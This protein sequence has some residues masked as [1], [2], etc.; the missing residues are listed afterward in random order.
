MEDCNDNTPIF[1]MTQ[2]VVTI[3]ENL[4]ADTKVL[5][6]RAFDL[7]MEDNGY[8]SYSIINMNEIPFTIDAFSGQIT[9][10]K[11]L[12]YESMSRSYKLHVR[13]S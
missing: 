4:P 9:T 7:D 10:D 1:N 12:D 13:A 2:S 6:V 3:S 5:R 8:I 11:V